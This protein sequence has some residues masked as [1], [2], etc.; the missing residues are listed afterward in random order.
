[1]EPTQTN[2]SPTITANRPDER[3]RKKLLVWGLISLIGPSALIIITILLYAL[4]N[5]LALN[6]AAPSGSGEDFLTH[7]P[8]GQ[9]IVNIILFLVGT[10]TVLTWLPGIIVGIILLVKRQG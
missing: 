10:I 7:P 9:S 1:M 5:F 8:I 4:F 3:T 2:P 6:N